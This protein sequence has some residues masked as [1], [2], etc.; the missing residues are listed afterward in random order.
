MQKAQARA[1]E[2]AV[3]TFQAMATVRSFANEDVQL[4]TTGSACS[5]ATAWR[6]RMWP[7]TLPLSGPVVYGMGWLN[8]MGT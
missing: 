7:S 8:S 3:E 4:H 6:R 2:V 1:S 5:R